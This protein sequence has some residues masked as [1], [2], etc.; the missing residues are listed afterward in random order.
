MRDGPEPC[1][2]R[3]IEVATLTDALVRAP[4]DRADLWLV[5]GAAGIGKTRLCREV[6]GVG[7]RLGWR[8]VWAHG[9]GGAGT[10]PFWPWV[11]VLRTLNGRPATQLAELIDPDEP[12]LDQFELFDATARALN[13]A[14]GPSPLL[15]I[16]DDLHLADPDSLHLLRFL[17]GHATTSPIL[18][19]GTYRL[20]HFEDPGTEVLT[21]LSR[22][23]NHIPLAGLGPEAVATLLDIDGS[24][25]QQS[26]ARGIQ[27]LTGGNP[28][29]VQEIARSQRVRGAGAPASATLRE[30]TRR[31][32]RQLPPGLHRCLAAIAVL[33]PG[34]TPVA[35]RQLA[36]SG[37]Q[38][39]C[40]ELED[41]LAHGVIERDPPD[42]ETLRFSHPLFAEVALELVPPSEL[43]ALHARA[44][45][46]LTADHH[47]ASTVASH[48]AQAG[49]A[50]RAEAV[51]TL[52]R[53]GQEATGRFA[54]AWAVSLLQR[55][56]ALLDTLPIDATAAS[57]DLPL[58]FEAVFALADAEHRARG[59]HAA[60]ET[61]LRAEQLAR[62]SG[63][64]VIVAR[65][66][67]RH[68][69]E[70]FTT[71]DLPRRRADAARAALSGLP[72]GDSGL[73]A[74][75]MAT[76]AAS[77]LA[78]HELA[79]GRAL[80]AE[81]VAM[82]RRTQDSLALGTA[83]VA[84]QVSDLG[85]ASLARRLASAREILALAEQTGDSSLAIHGRF[86]LKAALLESGDLRELN[87]QLN[88][89]QAQIGQV[90]EVRWARHSLWFRCMQAM[91][92]GDAAR[93]EELA[94][95]IG[96]IAD[97]LADPDGVGVYFGQLGVA[98]WLQG[99]LV[100]MEDAYLS[101][102]RDEPDEPLW[103]AVLAWVA[104]TDGREDEARGWA[105]HFPPASEVP[106][107]QHTLLTLC[108][109]AD[110]VAAVGDD[111]R[112]HEV[113]EALLPYAD[114]IIPIA[115]GAGLFGTVA[116][117]LA[118]LAMRL[119]RRDE[120]VG[121]CKRALAV[122]SRLG[123][124]AW[125]ADSQLTLAEILLTDPEP[126]DFDRAAPLIAEATT[127]RR[128]GTVVFEQRLLRLSALLP[129][130]TDPGVGVTASAL[131]SPSLGTTAHIE[132]LGAFEVRGIDGEV[133][134]WTSRK[135][136]TLL[137]VLVA[138][139]GAIVTREQAMAILWPD[140]DPD[141]LANRFSVALSAVRR[142]LDPQRT[143]EIPLVVS[144]DD[145]I[146]LALDHPEATVRVDAF[147]LL[148]EA[149]V[150]LAPDATRELLQ[151][152]VANFGGLPF[153]EEPYA[154]WARG[155]RAETTTWIGALLRRAIHLAEES[156]DLFETAESARR[157][158][159]IDPYDEPAH[160]ARILALRQLGAHG[161]ADQA[162][163]DF[164]SALSE[165]GLPVPAI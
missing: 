18:V 17:I 52:V 4:Q 16:L 132:V 136:R 96:E 67:A 109:M 72:T 93:V 153:A 6:A 81:A 155:L 84:Q 74:T 122:S 35:V 11:Q 53:A 83:L 146:R 148:K 95:E 5:S 48:L 76:V 29:F 55:A 164:R 123:A 82:A 131:P 115:M 151:I 79:P 92:D 19:L 2:G 51:S 127:I 65:S 117:T 3:Q 32:L 63:D 101:Q 111:A 108:S 46:I 34:A 152:T 119:G 107:S 126:G 22:S 162:T 9:W 141:L 85:P 142:A 36:P 8:S 40:S 91:L 10:P 160:R 49:E 59:R 125:I 139:G 134:R 21:H 140:Q 20:E 1:V 100:D 99:R 104:L 143:L 129:Q 138:H 159:D 27:Q 133:A 71:G 105:T 147:E 44:A 38:D 156:G 114:R 66:A 86:L 70:Y 39:D 25:D 157:L 24:P 7:G 165:L 62:R 75:L 154:D 68:G 149:R 30:V 58:H 28:L 116:R 45:Q 43:E 120:A 137:K 94:G 113:W 64:P 73:H 69:I 97:R 118:T 12:P 77:A 128:T 13:A 41:A 33:G 121:H 144:T 78:R 103:P 60:E 37:H 14:A 161:R 150:A 47:P 50:H 110:V 31:R 80:A 112:V 26:Q 54:H 158:L 102:L 42:A 130:D 23:A 15:L 124:R 106:E 145:G 98:R 90:G 89:Q 135:A 61:Y 163:A 87:S 56:V 88:I 57:D